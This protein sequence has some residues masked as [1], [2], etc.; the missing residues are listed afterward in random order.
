M[1]IGMTRELLRVEESSRA[2]AAVARCKLR[3]VIGLCL[4]DKRP[5]KQG[6]PAAVCVQLLVC[7]H[8]ADF[9][10][11]AKSM[12]SCLPKRKLF[13]AEQS[14]NSCFPVFFAGGGEK[15]VA[16]IGGISQIG[17]GGGLHFLHYR[18]KDLPPHFPFPLPRMRLAFLFFF[19]RGF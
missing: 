19:K 13:L 11:L 2:H 18:R 12:P 6:V 17:G 14:K 5:E 7:P 9:L 16:L 10:D 1:C 8:P 3:G 4:I 15:K